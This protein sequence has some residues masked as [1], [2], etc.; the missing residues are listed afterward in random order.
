MKSGAFKIDKWIIYYYV[1]SKKEKNRSLQAQASQKQKRRKASVFASCNNSSGSATVET[2]LVLPIFL[3]AVTVF[4]MIGQCIITEG[5]IQHAVTKTADICSREKELNKSPNVFLTFYSVFDMSPGDRSCITGDE[6]GIQLSLEELDGGER[7]QVK[8]V[9]RLRI[10]VLFFGKF[11]F[12]KRAVSVRRVF[13]GYTPHGEQESGEDRIVYVA[14]NGEVY[15]TNLSCSHICLSISGE[16]ATQIINSSRLQA[17]EKCIG[18]GEKP[19]RLY[20]TVFGECFHS[21]LNCSG[22]KRSVTAVQ[23]S[24]VKNMRMCTRCASRESSGRK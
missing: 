7:I 20:I 12:V 10:A 22:L 18:K 1:I 15:H 11:S 2:V 3:C 5:K 14:K 4:L 13:C 21:T 24:K 9:Y 8:A 19:S 6:A 17:C 16:K 23:L